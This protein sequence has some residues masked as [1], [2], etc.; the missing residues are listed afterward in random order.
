MTICSDSQTS[1]LISRSE[2]LSTLPLWR[3]WLAML[4]WRPVYDIEQRSIQLK[5]EIERLR[6]ENARLAEIES[7]LDAMLLN[8]DS[9]S[10]IQ[11]ETGGS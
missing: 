2:Y 8:F 10:P 7:K 11:N 3:R 9:C 5:S 4:N 1:T 6:T